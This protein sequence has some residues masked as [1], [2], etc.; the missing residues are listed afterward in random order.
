MR[1]TAVSLVFVALG[2]LVLSA[3]CM[4]RAAARGPDEAPPPSEPGISPRLNASTYFAHAHLLERQGS[5]EAAIQQYRK[6]LELSPKFTSAHNRLG[7]TLNKVARHADASAEFRI[8][9]QQTPGDANLHNNLG[10]SLYLEEK[11]PEAQA[12][13]HEALELQPDFARAHMNL[14]LVLAQLGR[15]SDA[16]REFTLACSEADAHYN[17]SVIQAQRRDFASA[18]RSA[19]NA[20]RINPNLE[21]ARAQLHLVAKMAAAAEPW[22]S[23]PP[24][25]A[26]A[27]AAAQPTPVV[28]LE[29]TTQPAAPERAECEPGPLVQPAD[30]EDY[31]PMLVD[32]L[33]RKVAS[34]LQGNRAEAQDIREEIAR[35]LEARHV[36]P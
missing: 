33:Q 5:Y 23:A 8:A 6:A 19:E 35:R 31:Q 7:I 12:E 4:G 30:S 29:S 21:A 26:V 18:A 27:D 36:R 32:E 2:A 24:A 1:R 10:F 9:L 17:L 34:A 3:G 16:L 20:L 14:G 15:D 22:Q 13:L 25:P 11:Y 28:V